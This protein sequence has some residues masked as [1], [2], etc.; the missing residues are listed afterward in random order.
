MSLFSLP[1]KIGSPRRLFKSHLLVFHDLSDFFS[2]LVQT[3]AITLVSTA[4]SMEMKAKTSK[5]RIQA[6]IN[7]N[8]PSANATITELG[9]MRFTSNPSRN[10]VDE[11]RT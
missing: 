9:M 7:W 4:L 11:G 8:H 6:V 3:S 1:S 2:A 10:T 5:N